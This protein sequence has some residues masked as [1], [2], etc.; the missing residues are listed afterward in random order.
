MRI[1]FRINKQAKVNLERMR[2]AINNRRKTIMMDNGFRAMAVLHAPKLSQA[3]LMRLCMAAGLMGINS[4]EGMDEAANPY[5][6]EVDEALGEAVTLLAQQHEVP[7]GTAARMAL[8]SGLGAM[9][10]S[11]NDLLS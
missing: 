6:I 7:I 4:P 11:W 1:T 9:M 5:S 8:E 2:E 10:L 3:N